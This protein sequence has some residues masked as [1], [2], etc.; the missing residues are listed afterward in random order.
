MNWREIKLVVVSAS[1]VVVAPVSAQ[2]DDVSVDGGTRNCIVTGRIRRTKIVDD[3]NVLFYLGGDIVLHNVLQGTCPG[4]EQGGTFIFNTSD[5][6][7]CKGD[8]FSSKMGNPL[9]AVRP[10]S[11]CWLGTY[12]DITRDEAGEMMEAKKETPV[13]KP[14][15]VPLPMPEPSEVGVEN[16]DPE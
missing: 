13:L 8:G 10:V 16:E 12:W 6:I 11:T 1:L 4:L 9:G 3:R 14:S 15:S 5:G 7:L 2:E